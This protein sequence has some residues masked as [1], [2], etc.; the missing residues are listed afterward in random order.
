M[1][2]SPLREG[3]AIAMDRSEQL[4]LWVCDRLGAQ[5]AAIAPASE[6]ASFRR[7][8]RITHGARTL[9][10]MDAPPPQENCAVF[11]HVAELFGRAGVNV[12]RILAQDLERGFLL[13]TD[14]GSTTY[15]Q[16]LPD[17]DAGRLYGD[18][19]EALVRIQLASTAGALPEYDAALL[20]REVTLFPDWYVERHLGRA[21]DDEQRSR[22]HRMFDT[23]IANNLAEPRVYV[24]RDY[25]SRNLMLTDPNPG[26]L[27]FQD[28][29]LGP[30]SYDLVSLLKDAY[31]E[32]PEERVIDWAVRYW[33]SAR[34]AGLP[35]RADFAEFYRDFEWMGVQRHLK[36]LGIFARLWHRDGK[37]RYLDD[38]PLVLRYL[39]R[40]ARRYR[41]LDPLAR[42]LDELHG[43]SPR[44]VDT[45]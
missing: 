38:L 4:R 5:P 9:I 44:L 26:I 32:W 11:V 15:L 42:L 8:F 17:A 21:L 13:L 19:L 33:E 27:D 23:V 36:V 20:R 6:D 3:N 41:E 14:F 1:I 22:L 39:E 7:Y 12:P 16:A 34:R 43:R 31:V 25:H 28:A 30:L 18:A 2:E 10:A 45:F 37:V 40:A 35:V 29:V 24:H